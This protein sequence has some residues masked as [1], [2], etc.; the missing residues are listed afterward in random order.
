MQAN[1]IAVNLLVFHDEP[2]SQALNLVVEAQ[3]SIVE[4]A[5]TSGYAV[6]D[7]K[8]AFTERSAK[9]ISLL[10]EKRNLSCRSVAAHMDIGSED[11]VE[12]FSARLRFSSQVGASI[13][14]TNTSTVDRKT[15]FIHNLRILSDKAGEFGITIALENPGDGKNNLFPNGEVGAA[16]IKELGL[17]NVRL[18]YDYSNAMSYSALKLDAER[19]CSRAIPMS[20][21]LHLK[22][23]KR[24]ESGT[25]H[26]W[27]FCAIGAGDH[28]YD[29]LLKFAKKTNKQLPMSLELPLHMQRG[30]DF[31]MHKRNEVHSEE[32]LI[33]AIRQ[34]VENILRIWELV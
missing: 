14:I 15:E 1:D 2:F 34:S 19:D 29:L 33:S 32:Y 30:A 26:G 22:D 24:W 20:A 23:M 17:P 31:L 10:L 28:D 6:F 3:C 13:V 11:A 12:R 4:L 5:Y 8:E 16:L 7:E 9:N 25:V 18:N 21:N 27:D